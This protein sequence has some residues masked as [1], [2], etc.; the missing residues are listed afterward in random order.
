[1]NHIDILEH[2]SQRR[3]DTGGHRGGDRERD[4]T[5]DIMR[6][7]SIQSSMQIKSLISYFKVRNEE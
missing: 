5:S 1:M 3:A 2:D 7:V 4:D 6:L